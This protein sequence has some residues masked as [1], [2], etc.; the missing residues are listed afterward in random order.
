M[1]TKRAAIDC[2]GCK[3]TI[4]EKEYLKCC[5]CSKK[6]DLQCANVPVKRYYFSMNKEQRSKW[7]CQ[8]CRY[9]KP[10]STKLN[11]P[12]RDLKDDDIRQSPVSEGE[13]MD[14]AAKNETTPTKSKSSYDSP[15]EQLLKDSESDCNDDVISTICAR[16]TSSIKAELPSIISRLLKTEFSTIKHDL[17][18]FRK[19]LDYISDTNDELMQKI[20]KLNTENEQLKN[21]NAALQ[22]TVYQLSDR[23]NNM[24]QHLREANIEVHGVPESRSE[25]LAVTLEQCAKVVGHVLNNDD[26]V[27]CT[28]VAKQNKESKLPRTIVVKFKNVRCRDNFY[29]AVYRYNKSHQNDKLN[30]SLLGIAGEKRPIY[31]SEH[32]SPANK[33]LHAAARL[34]AK[35]LKYQFVWI[36]NG[37]IYVRKNPE[38]QYILIK[39]DESLKL[40]T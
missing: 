2:G 10:K 8:E 16:V 27:N 35:E 4:T 30:S 6:Y 29:S 39:S 13:E 32:L 25:N 5:E 34:K 15:T 11:T 33:A 36:R 22:T 18:E 20:E 21:V 24:E 31:I 40:M 17:Q 37:R 9:K 23:L 7:I 28:R 12:L 38:S 14:S 3:R 19:S 1:A 26:I